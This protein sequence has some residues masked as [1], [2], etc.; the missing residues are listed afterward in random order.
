MRF[1]MQSNRPIPTF[2]INLKKRDDRRAH[3]LS[4]FRG[5]SEFKI[6]IK[7]AVEHENGAAGLWITLVDII[8]GIDQ[9][10]DHILICEDDHQFTDSYSPEILFQSIESARQKRADILSGGVSW[11][12]SSVAMSENLYWVQDFSGLQFTIIFRKFFSTILEA[13]FKRGDA[14]DYKISALTSRKFFIYPFIST[15]KEFGYSDV[16]ATNNLTGHV[17]E[18]FSQSNCCVQLMRK[19]CAHYSYA[20]GEVE[21][22]SFYEEVSLPVFVL[23]NLPGNAEHLAAIRKKFEGRNEFDLAIIDAKFMAVREIIELAIANDDDLAIFCSD[24][25]VFTENYS[26]AF[27]LKNIVE[28]HAQGAGFLCGG[29]AGFKY[30]IQVSAHRFWIDSCLSSSFFVIYKNL[31][32]KFLEEPFSA[33]STPEKILSDITSSK[34]VI[35]PF[36]SAGNEQ[37]ENRLAEINSLNHETKAI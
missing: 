18:L 20:P 26:S 1:E 29:V 15:Q 19:V 12:T 27:L 14:A 28:A 17:N 30:A 33:E 31:F 8:K 35:Y 9:Q 7:E 6:N 10:E 13:E 32:T 11:L 34:M 21:L 24:D 22:P 25:H 36:I 5:R 4:E 37:E 23:N 16:T 3:I 2:I